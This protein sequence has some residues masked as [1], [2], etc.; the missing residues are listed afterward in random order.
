MPV[1][2]AQPAKLIF[3]RSDATPPL[4]TIAI[5]TYQREEMLLEA[6]VSALAQDAEIPLEII[7]VDN[8]PHSHGNVMSRVDLSL[9][10]HA[11]RYYVND[12]N[13]GMFGNWNQCIALAR[14]RWITLLHDDDWL[15]PA[16]LSSMLPLLERGINFAVCRVASGSS[17]PNLA[18]LQRGRDSDHVVDITIDD[19]IFGTPSPA[20]GVLIL[21]QLLIRIGGFDA[22]NYPC[23]DYLTYSK[24]AAQV[25]SARLNRTLA[26]YRTTDSQTFKGNTL[27]MMIRQS[28]QIKKDLLR[29]AS[30]G[31]AL[32]YI[33]SMAFWFRLAR[34]HGKPMSDL[35]LDWQ[36]RSAAALSHARPLT[37]ALETVRR[38]VKRIAR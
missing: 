16:F 5:P 36:L 26:Y 17:G 34:Q 8:D 20:P 7:V 31:S 32:T 30:T 27:Q 28:N 22:A 29:R 11:V 13:L 35:E 12:A 1:D 4:V 9:S 18:A 38:C 15:A 3:E 25:Q 33:L 21:R 37:L 10:R 23:A 14:G 2:T 24:C 19:L 6:L